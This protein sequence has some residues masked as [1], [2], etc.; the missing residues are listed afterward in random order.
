MHSRKKFSEYKLH[1]KG[2]RFGLTVH[3]RKPGMVLNRF[4]KIKTMITKPYVHLNSPPISS[5]NL[6]LSKFRIDLL[7]WSLLTSLHP[8]TPEW[9]TYVRGQNPVSSLIC[10][11]WCYFIQLFQE[12]NVLKYTGKLLAKFSYVWMVSNP[13]CK[14]TTRWTYLVQKINVS[15]CVFCLFSCHWQWDARRGESGEVICHSWVV[16]AFII[17][18]NLILHVCNFK[19][20]LIIFPFLQQTVQVE[21]GWSRTTFE[22]SVP[23]STYLVCFAVHQFKFVERTSNRGIPVS[24]VAAW[25]RFRW[26]MYSDLHFFLNESAVFIIQT[27]VF[28]FPKCI[29]GSR[30]D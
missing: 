24:P 21:N 27:R 15:F 10:P 14:I 13:W 4:N 17:I 12:Q 22:K 28:P 25:T 30:S 9:C 5:A 1:R 20:K 16:L 18:W 8:L 7:I 19:I 26:Q 3:L 11:E 29:L 23:M 2:C 6:C